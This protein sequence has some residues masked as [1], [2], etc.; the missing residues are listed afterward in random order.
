MARKLKILVVDDDEAVIELVCVL[1]NSLG[2]E[3]VGFSSSPAAATRLEAE[4]FDAVVTDLEM[5]LVDGAELV[6]RVRAS[7]LNART[8]VAILTGSSGTAVAEESLRA[9]ANV[10]LQKPAT[11]ENMR[12][13]LEEIRAQ[14]SRREE[15]DSASRD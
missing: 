1:L 14:L 3:A 9:G 7:K 11:L 13:L 6:W 10:F 2:A 8:F 12:K 15:P 4:L 5:P